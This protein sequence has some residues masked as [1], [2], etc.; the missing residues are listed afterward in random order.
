MTEPNEQTRAEDAARGLRADQEASEV[1]GVGLHSENDGKPG[2]KQT[3]DNII[4]HALLYQMFHCCSA[5]KS[6]V[7]L[8][9]HGLQQARLPC[10]SLSLCLRKFMSIKSVMLSNHFSLCCPLLLLPS[11]FPSIRVSSSQ[12]AVPVRWP[13]YWSFNFS[14]SA[15][16]EPSEL[17][18]FR[19]DQF[20]LL[21]VQG[22][23][24]SLL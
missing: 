19:I 23:L 18:S 12:S 14:I 5:T 21:A 3:S 15:S 11:V 2:V 9:P 7:T 4:R 16:N 13:E 6:Y 22:T 20:D 8:R 10:S 17:L 24:K 1:P